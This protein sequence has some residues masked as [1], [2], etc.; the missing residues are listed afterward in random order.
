MIE[1]R[2][3]TLGKRFVFGTPVSD[4][5]D[6]DGLNS[7]YTRILKTL[8]Y[9]TDNYP[10]HNWGQYLQRSGGIEWSKIIIGGHSQGSGHAAY[11][12][13]KFLVDRVLM[14]SGPNDY[15]NYYSDTAPWVSNG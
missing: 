2:W 4:V 8:E 7:I 1:R 11:I 14:F 9:L 6:V 12:A 3:T 5:V 13:Q 15:S 10:D